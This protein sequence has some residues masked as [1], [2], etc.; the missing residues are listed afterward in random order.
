MP[1]HTPLIGITSDIAPHARSGRPTCTVALAYAQCVARAGGTPMLLPPIPSLVP[2]HLAACDGFVFTG[3]DDPRMEPFGEPTHPKACVMNPQRQEYEITLLRALA[4]DRPDAPVLGICLGM[5]LMSLVAGG[6]IHQHLPDTL[7]THAD[8][9]GKDHPVHP[10][11]GPRGLFASVPSWAG[12][13]F[14]GP[15]ASH[16]KQGISDPG[17]LLVL[18]HAHDGVIEAVGDPRRKFYVG[19]QWHPERTADPKVGQGVFDAFV[20]AVLD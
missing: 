7:S 15:A 18:A 14:E 13:Q 8:H 20:R 4:R 6:K 11:P 3:G 5:Q 12:L 17:S 19:V 10:E 2:A 16:H 1:A 9:A